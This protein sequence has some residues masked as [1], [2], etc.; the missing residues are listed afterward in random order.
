[1]LNWVI[2]DWIATNFWVGLS[3]PKCECDAEIKLAIKPSLLVCGL[4]NTHSQAYCR[5]LL[6]WGYLPRYMELCSLEL[7]I[8][9]QIYRKVLQIFFEQ[10]TVSL[11][12][13]KNTRNSVLR[14]PTLEE[15]CFL[16]W[17]I[18]INTLKILNRVEA[19]LCLILV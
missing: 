1:M 7:K 16:S 2:R 13:G 19:K 12:N 8:C 10:T 4:S 9:L 5:A 17:F 11:T 6:A 15:S 18:S 3:L 14:S